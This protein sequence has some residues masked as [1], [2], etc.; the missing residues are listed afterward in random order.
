MENK[1]IKIM[2]ILDGETLSNSR[3]ILQKITSRI[4]D[5]VYDENQKMVFK[6]EYSKTL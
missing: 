3:T 4:N 5:I 1:I 6:T 2:E